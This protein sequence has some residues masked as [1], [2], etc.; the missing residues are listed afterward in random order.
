MFGPLSDKIGRKKVVVYGLIIMIFGSVICAVSPNIT[1]LISGRF[2]EGFG[3]GAASAVFRAVL[4]DVYKGD[5]LS[6]KGSYLAVASAFTVSAIPAVG[7]YIQRYLGWRFNFVFI[8]LYA[9]CT[10]LLTHFYL[11][12]TNKNLN[13]QATKLSNILSKYRYL[14]SSTIFLGYAGCGILVFGGLTAYLSV[15]PFLFQ[16]VIGLSSVQFGWLAIFIAVGLGVGAISNSIFVQKVGRHRMLKYGTYFQIS[17][18]AL[19]LLPALFG[20]IDVLFIMVPMLIYMLGAGLVFSNAFAGA[21]HFFSHI[22]G[23]TGALYGCCQII[24]GTITSSIMAALHAKDQIPLAV[25]LLLVG[26]FSFFFQKLGH[27]FTLK[28]EKK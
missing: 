5:E 3:V 13:P 8:I 25:T 11:K 17:S 6:Q 27:H 18:G 14:L 15:S 16:N 23:F 26:I 21:S 10:I 2:I 1:L 24:G 22:A 28:C 9:V 7:G 4:R 19:M 20:E 12:E